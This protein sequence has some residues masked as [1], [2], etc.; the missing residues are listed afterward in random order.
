MNGSITVNGIQRL[1]VPAR[2]PSFSS[3]PIT[4]TTSLGGTI[5]TMCGFDSI[6]PSVN[7]T[8]RTASQAS[9]RLIMAWSRI[10]RTSRV[11]MRV[12][13]RCGMNTS[14]FEPPSSRSITG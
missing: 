9:L 10:L 14:S 2:L 1:M 11:S 4:T 3:N 13:G 8:C 5:C 7:S 6:S 12:S